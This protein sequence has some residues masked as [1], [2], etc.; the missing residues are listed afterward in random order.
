MK[1]YIYLSLAIISFLGIVFLIFRANL[2]VSFNNNLEKSMFLYA[3]WLVRNQTG[4]GDFNYELDVNT[5]EVLEGYNIV[6]QAGS[7]YS[8]AQVYRYEGGE[9]Y[10]DSIEKGIQFFQSYYEDI[11]KEIPTTAIN[12]DGTKKSNT[13]ALYLLALI[14]Y[15]EEDTQAREKYI[16]EANR[17]AN[18]LLLTQKEDGSFIYLLDT[19]KESDYNNGES[20]YALI[21]MYKLTSDERYLSSA[22]KAAEYILSKYSNEEFNYSVYAWAMEGFAHLYEIEK[23]SRYWNFMKMYT[24]EYFKVSGISVSIYF[25]T[26]TGYPPKANLGVYLE[27]LAHVA[28]IAKDRD[29]DFYITIREF[30]GNSLKYLMS[31][32]IDGPRSDRETGFELISGGICYD[33]ECATQRIDITHHN[34]SAIYL[35][36]RYVI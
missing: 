29:Y 36:L 22:T 28:W 26:S 23:D 20:F 7:L 32:Q 12:H 21:R 11:E 27:G 2:P 10:E 4:D 16:D 35:Y 13:V 24:E 6:R 14:E 33:Y 34:L 30:M 25:D 8:L 9:K 3:D 19:G 17:L 1:K 31:L 18:Y 15:M 5:G